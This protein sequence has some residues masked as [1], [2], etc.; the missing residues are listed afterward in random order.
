MLKYDNQKHL[1]KE[2]KRS[3][4]EAIKAARWNAKQ[5]EHDVEFCRSQKC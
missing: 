3:R 1:P 5:V 2:Y 4:Q